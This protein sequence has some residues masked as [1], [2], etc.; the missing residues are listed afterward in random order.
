MQIIFTRHA[1]Q[2]MLQRQVSLEQVIETIESPDDV[3]IGENGE[4]I[5]LKNYGNREVRVAYD[6]REPDVA[7]V[8]T[9]MKPRVHW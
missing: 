1:R 3:T 2:R 4:T 8:F 7:V 6:L 5:A 9:V